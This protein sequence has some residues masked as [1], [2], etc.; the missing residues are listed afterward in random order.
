MIEKQSKSYTIIDVRDEDRLGGHIPGSLNYPASSFEGETVDQICHRWGPSIEPH[1][2]V[3]HCRHSLNRAPI[4]ARLMRQRLDL[5]WPEN[6]I[7]IGVLEFGFEGW[8]FRFAQNSN[9]VEDY[10][11]SLW[12]SKLDTLSPLRKRMY[13]YH[14]E[15]ASDA[16]DEDDDLSA[17]GAIGEA[18]AHTSGMQQM[19]FDMN[20]A[21]AGAPDAEFDDI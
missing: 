11:A 6:I 14:S 7:K 5:L 17:S 9:L 20:D 8:V 13:T 2:L 19:F 21:D 1:K 3:F 4:C 18:L 10:I 16:S 12:D 15:E